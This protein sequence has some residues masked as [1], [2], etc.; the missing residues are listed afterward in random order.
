MSC[1]SH[2]QYGIGQPDARIVIFPRRLSPLSKHRFCRSKGNQ[3]R[4]PRR[5]RPHRPRFLQIPSLRLRVEGEAS[6]RGA[7]PAGAISHVLPGEV[8][9]V[10]Q[11]HL[12]GLRPPRRLRAPPD[13][14]GPAL[15]LP[16][17]AGRC[18]GRRQGGRRGGAFVHVCLH[19]PVI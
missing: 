10:R 14:P 12:G 6:A 4:R 11:V 17:L 2:R 19:H 5:H 8:R 13:S 3:L 9:V 1:A 7:K 18:P 16:R 15:R